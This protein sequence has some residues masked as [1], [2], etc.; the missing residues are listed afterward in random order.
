MSIDAE[1][2]IMEEEADRKK[3]AAHSNFWALLY[4]WSVVIVFFASAGGAVYWFG[5]AP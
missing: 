5:V 1:N 3:P 4:V 2:E